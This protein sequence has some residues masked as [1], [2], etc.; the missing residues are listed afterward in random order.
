MKI[1]FLDIE[2]APNVVH[3]WGLWK[4][5]VSIK[6]VLNSSYTLCWAAKWLD[7]DEVLFHSVH[8][9]SRRRMI[10]AVYAL[11]NEADAVVHFNGTRFDMPTLNKE[12]VSLG[13]RP[14]APYRNIDLYAVCKKEFRFPSF[15]LDY[16]L[17]ELNIGEKVPHKGHRLWIECMGGRGIS[18]ETSAQAWTTMQEYNIADVLLTEKLYYAVLPWIQAHPN[19]N[20]YNDDGRPVCA[21]CGS[22]RVHRKAMYYG[23][24][25]KYKRYRC[26]DCG[27]WLRGRKTQLSQETKDTMLV[28]AR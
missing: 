4:Q 9:G 15:K 11:I 1:L 6:Q 14:P 28:S 17:Q 2:T 16:I 26:Y 21:N 18:R 10:Q 20:A 23:P 22:S 24:T 5:D 12:F 19:Y 7:S 13:I 8:N 3:V 27:K 25:F